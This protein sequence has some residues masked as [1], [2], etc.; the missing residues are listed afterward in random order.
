ME[1]RSSHSQVRVFGGSILLLITYGGTGQ[2]EVA[3]S[4]NPSVKQLEGPVTNRPGCR[5]ARDCLHWDCFPRTV[6]M[7]NAIDIFY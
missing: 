4:I 1:R 5:L 7:T 2:G 3:N 6:M